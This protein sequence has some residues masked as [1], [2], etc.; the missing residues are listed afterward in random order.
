MTAHLSMFDNPDPNSLSLYVF[1]HRNSFS[2]SVHRADTL[3]L[4]NWGP[5]RRLSDGSYTL[6]L[7]TDNYDEVTLFVNDPMTFANSLRTWADALEGQYVWD[8]QP[9]Q[10]SL[11]T[12]EEVSP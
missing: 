8:N 3:R 1:K 11:F 4:S 12:Y 6:A 5:V 9:Q 2:V 7:S 10:D